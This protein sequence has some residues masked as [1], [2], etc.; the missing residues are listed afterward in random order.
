MKLVRNELYVSDDG[1][2][3]PRPTDEFEEIPVEMVFRSVGYRGVP[4]PGLP[5]H[6][7]WGIVPNEK[8]RVVDPETN[9]PVA[10]VYVSGWIKR[11]PTGIIGT[12]KPDA[13][14]TVECML[15]DAA[16]GAVLDAQSPDPA[17]VVEMVRRGQPD[18][19]TWEDWKNLQE[20]EEEKGKQVG[21][22][23][24]KF[25]TVEEMLAALGRG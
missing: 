12:N 13:G 8:G 2:L 9:E 4:L 19:V 5:F 20:A 6:D 1:S 7:R 11:G 23:R 10:G 3:R 18:Y 14:E 16:G 21:R 22:P 24:V 17:G 25:T 15:E